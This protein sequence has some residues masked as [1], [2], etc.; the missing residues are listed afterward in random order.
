MA[1]LKT[2]IFFYIILVGLFGLFYTRKQP[3]TYWTSFPWFLITLGTLD[4]SGLLIN[5]F[6]L[7]KYPNVN[8]YYYQLFVIP[9]QVL[10]Y[11]WIINRNSI[12]NKNRLYYIGSAVFIISVII[13]CFTLVNL[14]GYFFNSFSYM[15][16][17]ILMLAHIMRYFYQLSKSDRILFFYKERMFWVSLGLLVFWLGSLP[18]FGIFNYLFINYQAIGKFYFKVVLIL[19]YIMYTCFLISFIWAVKEK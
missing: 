12:T 5:N 3:K 9:F 7:D 11:F 13:E 8:F 6:F 2:Y 14:T 17:N 15:V 18:F 16:A 4:G 19:N 10:Y 1:A